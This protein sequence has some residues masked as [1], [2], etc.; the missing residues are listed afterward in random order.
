MAVDDQGAFQSSGEPPPAAGAWQTLD[1]TGKCSSGFV[2]SQPSIKAFRASARTTTPVNG[3]NKFTSTRCHH[4]MKT[5][6]VHPHGALRHLINGVTSLFNFSY[7]ARVGDYNIHQ[8]DAQ[9]ASGAR[10]IHGFAQNRSIPVERQHE[11]FRSYYE[12]A[13]D[14]FKDPQFLRLG[15]T[16]SGQSLEDATFDKR[17]MDE[18][19]ALNQAHFLSEA[20]YIARDGRRLGKEEVQR[21]FQ[22]FIDAGTLGPDQYFGHFIHTNESIIEKTAAAGSAMSWQPLSNG[23]LGS[24]IADPSISKP[25]SESAWGGNGEAN[26]GYRQPVRERGWGTPDPRYY[27]RLGRLYPT[28]AMSTQ[29][30]P[31]WA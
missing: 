20:Y 31:I 11:S 26:A 25:G 27:G 7:N 22:N 24:G 6:L 14:H 5:L 17:L 12:Y 29:K 10:F 13:K 30:A 21:N 28:F 19:G 2:S 15:I 3:A 18:F 23:R 16:G 4:P 8:L 1:A 9:F